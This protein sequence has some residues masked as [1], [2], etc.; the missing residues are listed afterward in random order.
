MVWNT[1]LA[2]GFEWGVALQHLE[3]GK[4]FKGRADR[5]AAKTRLREFSA[6]AGRQVFKDY[7]AFPALTS[8]SLGDVSVH[9]DRQRGGQ[10]DP[11]RGPTR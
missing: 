2:I 4:I 10:R 5:E 9:F 8:L 7:V 3:I 6:K 1:I 11:Q